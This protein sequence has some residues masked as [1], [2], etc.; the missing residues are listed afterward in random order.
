MT[1]K[2]IIVVIAFRFNRSDFSDYYLECSVNEK[3]FEKKEMYKILAKKLAEELEPTTQEIYDFLYSNN[4]I[5]QPNRYISLAYI[6]LPFE[7]FNISLFIDDNKVKMS[8]K[9][10]ST[11]EFKTANDVEKYLNNNSFE[12]SILEGCV[13]NELRMPSKLNEPDDL[14]GE[15]SIVAECYEK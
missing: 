12:D 2:I 11:N 1:N 8:L 3:D 15:L 10:F 13:G 14:L 5:K 9:M 4:D 6:M 7:L